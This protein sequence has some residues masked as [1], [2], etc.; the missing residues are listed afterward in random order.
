MTTR[1][2]TG[3][4]GMGV[5]VPV[6]AGLVVAA[7]AVVFVAQNAHAVALRFLWV[8]F[9]ASPAVL[10]L[11]TAVVAVAVTEALGALWRRRRRRVL[12]EREE[13]AELRTTLAPTADAEQDPSHISP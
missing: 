12:T 7:G 9:R 5:W 2:A 10:V 6:V 11:A 1:E 4:R 13:L 8:H 3:F